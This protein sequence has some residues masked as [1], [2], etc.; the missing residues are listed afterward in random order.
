M[1]I[2]YAII[3]FL[4]FACKTSND[5]LEIEKY[6]TWL[7]DADNGL[8][9]A[10]TMNNV[11]I[12]AR[13]LPAN[14]L[15]YKEFRSSDG[16]AYDSILKAYQCGLTFEIELQAD[17]ADKVYGNLLYYGIPDADAL[18][19]RTRY[20][21]FKVSEFITLTYGDQVYE[22]ILS[23][24]EGYN[25]IGNKINFVVVFELPQFSCGNFTDDSQNELILTY[26]DPYWDLGVNHFSFEKKYILNVPKLKY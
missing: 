9:K 17:K 26:K 20:L 8:Y 2:N 5:R 6:E 23:N 16:A 3:F 15:A 24:F 21:N 19:Q 1:R 4:V 11:S 10:K 22:P 25:S 18:T 13:F 14:Y 12:T 7:L